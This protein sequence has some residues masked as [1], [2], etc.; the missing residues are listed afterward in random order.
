[1]EIDKRK[2]MGGREGGW[3]MTEGEEKSGIS[4]IEKGRGKKS[5]KT[6]VRI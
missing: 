6:N 5:F 3:D 1:M 2:G 4:G